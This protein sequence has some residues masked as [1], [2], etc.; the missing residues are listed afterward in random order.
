MPIWLNIILLISSGIAGVIITL[1]TQHFRYKRQDKY[2]LLTSFVEN[3]FDLR[4]EEFSRAI[5]KIYIVFR[6]DLEVVYAVVEFNNA[7]IRKE[8]GDIANRKLYTLY[9]LMCQNL[10]INPIGEFLFFNVFNNKT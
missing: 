8:S 2:E 4:G 1:I 10:K 3:R 9:K 7:L 5:N 6:E